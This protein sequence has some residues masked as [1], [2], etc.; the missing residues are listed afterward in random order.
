MAEYKISPERK[1]ELIGAAGV[2]AD[3][4]S[5]VVLTVRKEGFGPGT[6]MGI[7]TRFLSAMPVVSVLG[8]VSDTEEKAFLGREFFDNLSGTDA[9][10]LWRPAFAGLTEDETERWL[11]LTADI[12]ATAAARRLA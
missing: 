11:D 9:T 4:V 12:A 6:A 10:A 2:M 8:S 7:L 1:D 3:F 5:Y